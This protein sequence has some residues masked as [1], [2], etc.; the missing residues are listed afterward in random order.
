M[1]TSETQ[2]VEHAQ[3]VLKG[4]EDAETACKEHAREISDLKNEVG[5]LKTIVKVV[6]AVLVPLILEAIRS[7]FVIHGGG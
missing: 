3:L 4:L 7:Y 6:S 5:N 1:Q 2:W